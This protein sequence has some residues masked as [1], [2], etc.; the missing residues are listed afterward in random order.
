M[1][2]HSIMKWKNNDVLAEQIYTKYIQNW[3]AGIVNLVHAY[4]PELIILSGG[5]MYSGDEIL[6]LIKK[7]VL[8]SAWTYWGELVFRVAENPDISPLLGMSYLVKKELGY[9]CN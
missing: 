6:D 1:D 5:I 9:A 4:D 2:F 3:S 7:Y 8:K